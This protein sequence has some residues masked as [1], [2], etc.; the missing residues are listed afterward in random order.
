MDGQQDPYTFSD[1]EEDYR[2][3]FTNVRKRPLRQIDP[4]W[5]EEALNESDEDPI[6]ISADEDDVGTNVVLV[7][8]KNVKKKVLG[9]KNWKKNVAINRKKRG[10]SYIS[11]KTK[12]EVRARE[13]QEGDCCTR[14]CVQRIPKD[15]K[16]AICR[17]HRQKL[18]DDNLRRAHINFLVTRIP[19][20]RHRK[21]NPSKVRNF[22]NVYRLYYKN[23]QVRVSYDTF[24]NYP[25]M[26]FSNVVCNH[27]NIITNSMD[28]GR[29]RKRF[30]LCF[31]CTHFTHYQRQF[32][33]DSYFFQM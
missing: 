6:N 29:T 28:D 23:G 21:Q 3:Q 11:Q 9:V 12:Q 15:V 25:Y 4:N 2:P 19:V 10:D 30:L 33:S 31:E 13:V 16:D 5:A 22:T 17:D 20:K 14:R 27:G 7:G 1:S 26:N 32:L 18:N 24:C 8:D